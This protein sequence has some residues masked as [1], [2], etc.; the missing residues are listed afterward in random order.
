MS[1]TPPRSS[2]PRRPF[3]FAHAIRRAPCRRSLT[4]RLTSCTQA[5]AYHFS[6]SFIIIART[7]TFTPS[8][9][10]CHSHHGT[11]KRMRM[12]LYRFHYFRSPWAIFAS[13]WGHDISELISSACVLSAFL[14]DAL[15]SALSLLRISLGMLAAEVKT[16]KAAATL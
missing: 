2:P 4:H 8:C 1:I 10:G 16:C 5:Y 13:T 12:R 6:L 9:I 11:R 15:I 14:A 7:L 3:L